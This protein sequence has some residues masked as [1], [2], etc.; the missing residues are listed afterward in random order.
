MATHKNTAAAAA[1]VAVEDA[2]RFTIRPQEVA[3]AVGWRKGEVDLDK[4]IAAFYD[5]VILGHRVDLA[6]F[7]AIAKG[8]TR[9]NEAQAAYLFGRNLFVIKQVGDECAAKMSDKNV[10]GDTILHP[11]G[12]KPQA[13]RALVQSVTGKKDWGVFVAR[14]QQEADSRAGVQP[15]AR[16]K[17]EGKSDMVY[18]R[19]TVGAVI[20]RLA[21]D[22]EKLD[23]TIKPDVAAKLA[24]FLRDTLKGYG[25]K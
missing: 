8:E 9:S 25:I 23:G 2:V 11:V 17:K 10:S 14:L 7:K 16:G 1:V 3:A 5:A 6:H 18:V 12:R 19:D 20:K 15:E 22:V 4:K 13:K 24:A 21:R